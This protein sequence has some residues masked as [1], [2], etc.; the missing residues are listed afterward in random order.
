MSRSKK[1]FFVSRQ[2]PL[3]KAKDLVICTVGLIVPE[4]SGLN[5]RLVVQEWHTKNL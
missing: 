5:E 3:F 1:L 4:V 2:K